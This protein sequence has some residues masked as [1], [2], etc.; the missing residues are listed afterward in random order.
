MM[1]CILSL[2]PL[3]LSFF[4]TAEPAIA[5]G[6]VPVDLK[7]LETVSGKGLMLT[8]YA[9]IVGMLTLYTIWMFVKQRSIGHKIESLKK[10]LV[11]S[12]TAKQ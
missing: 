7:T 9:V 2:L 12:K 6:Y 5:K 3:S 4:L 1:I 8:C 11:E 10:Q